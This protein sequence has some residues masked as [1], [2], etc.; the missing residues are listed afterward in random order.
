MYFWLKVDF[1]F[2]SQAPGLHSAP[3]APDKKGGWVS[4]TEVDHILPIEDGGAIYEE[5]NLQGLCK[6]HHSRKTAR[7]KANRQRLPVQLTGEGGSRI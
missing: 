3:R 4:A 1:A 6:S 5:A 7:D 2:G